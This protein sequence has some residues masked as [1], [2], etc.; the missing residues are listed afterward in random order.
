MPCSSENVGD[1]NANNG[2]MTKVWGPA[3]WLF[4]HSVTLGY[5]QDPDKY[6]VENGLPNGSTRKHY[7]NYFR[8][9]GHI[10]P[11]K[12]CRDS[13]REFATEI[14]LSKFMKNRDTLSQ[15]LWIIHN[16]VNDKLGSKYCDSDFNKIKTRYESYRAKCKALTTEERTVNENKGCVTPADGTP[17]KCLIDI[18]QTNRG[19]VTR[20]G[21]QPSPEEVIIGQT[22]HQNCPR[23]EVT[24]CSTGGYITII[25]LICLAL[26]VGFLCGK[27]MGSNSIK[28]I[29]P[30][31]LTTL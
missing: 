30:Q 17:K 7:Y 11:C 18:V 9:V 6:D 8:E 31:S 24:R 20:R 26:L 12:Y 3:G 13:Y 29:I 2:M 28:G 27:S 1:P 25:L 14:P 21:N 19:D 23:P 5:P 10:L 15:W 22:L 4:L 16:R